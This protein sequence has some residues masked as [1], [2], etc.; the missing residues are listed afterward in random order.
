MKPTAY[1][2][3]VVL[4]ASSED[5][6]EHANVVAIEEVAERLS[7]AAREAESAREWLD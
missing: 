3:D 2:R 6:P 5:H 4:R 7:F 1:I